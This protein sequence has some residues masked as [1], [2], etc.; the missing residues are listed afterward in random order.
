MSGVF[1]WNR[2]RNSLLLAHADLSMETQNGRE[3]TRRR[4]CASGR[5]RKRTQLKNKIAGS[6]TK[7]N[8]QSGE[9][10]DV[11]RSPKKFKGV[12]GEKAA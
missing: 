10:M 5:G 9:F 4:Q 7:R 6:W 2:N 12:R 3:Q 8:K 11:K 1:P